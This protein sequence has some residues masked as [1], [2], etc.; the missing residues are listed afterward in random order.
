MSKDA[1]N[2]LVKT[3]NA[4]KSMSYGKYVALNSS[5]QITKFGQKARD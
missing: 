1:A 2:W 5:G 3:K 4:L